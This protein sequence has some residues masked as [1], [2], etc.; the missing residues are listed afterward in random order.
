MTNLW[1]VK[2]FQVITQEAEVAATTHT[3]LVQ[4]IKLTAVHPAQPS[5]KPRGM[6]AVRVAVTTHG[7][8][9]L[10]EMITPATHAVRAVEQM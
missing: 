9:L 2:M 1:L 6:T 5:V 4:K 10:K 7:T 8:E 3:A